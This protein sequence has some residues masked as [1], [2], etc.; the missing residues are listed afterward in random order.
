MKSKQDIYLIY[1]IEL[2]S[3][4]KNLFTFGSGE[5]GGTCML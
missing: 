5:I 1:L 4:K 3:S 2:V